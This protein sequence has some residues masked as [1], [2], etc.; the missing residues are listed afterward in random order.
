VTASSVGPSAGWRIPQRTDR[1][2][3]PPTQEHLPGQM[4]EFVYEPDSY[5]PMAMLLDSLEMDQQ[6]TQT[7]YYVNDP[8]GCPS[9]V[10]DERGSVLWAAG[11]SAWGNVEFVHVHGIENPIR[12]QGQYADTETGLHYN[13]YRYFDPHAGLFAGQDPIGLEGG[14]NVYELAPNIFG[15]IDP[16]GLTG[17]LVT[18]YRVVSRSPT[19]IITGGAFLRARERGA[20]LLEAWTI[21][22][23][24][25]D[26]VNSSNPKT[27]IKALQ[28]AQA[29]GNKSPLISTTLNEDLARK[30]LEE[31]RRKGVDA[32]LITI[33]GPR[34]KG[35]DFERE[36][37]SLGGRSSP[38]RAKD[39]EL[40][41]FGIPDLFVPSTGQSKSGFE[42]IGRE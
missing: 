30:Q 22:R 10:I 15:W 16:L 23:K 8:N 33:Q 29:S 37:A 1:A 20:G 35:V 9:R 7:L 19:K 2:P 14:I 5:E 32:E 21:R 18:V 28:D 40:E 11:F 41:E 25:L 26:A 31:L 24:L 13:R 38:G 36:F 27:K 42:I 3:E 6:R 17:C 34:D 12:L 4:R 39:A